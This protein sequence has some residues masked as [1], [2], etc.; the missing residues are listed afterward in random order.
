MQFIL[1]SKTAIYNEPNIFTK[2]LKSILE[3]RVQ[4][5][6]HCRY[7]LRV[8]G[9]TCLYSKL[10]PCRPCLKEEPDRVNVSYILFRHC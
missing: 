10:W 7:L 6:C 3:S 1:I 9:R 2:Y 8:G 4:A 5:K